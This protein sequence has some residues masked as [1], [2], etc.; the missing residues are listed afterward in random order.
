MLN[1]I[2]KCCQELCI[3]LGPWWILFMFY[4]RKFILNKYDNLLHTYP[5]YVLFPI[6]QW[7]ASEFCKT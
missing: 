2:R 5:G 6:S 3:G 4:L 1:R 7:I